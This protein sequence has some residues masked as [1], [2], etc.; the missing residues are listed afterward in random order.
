MY[1][2][3]RANLSKPLKSIHGNEKK[4]TGIMNLIRDR[5]NIVCCIAVFMEFIF[6]EFPNVFLVGPIGL[7]GDSEFV[8]KLINTY[9]K[10]AMI[11]PVDGDTL[12]EI[13]MKRIGNYGAPCAQLARIYAD[14]WSA[15]LAVCI[16]VWTVS[17]INK[18]I[19]KTD[20]LA[21]QFKI[22]MTLIC[23]I[24][25][26]V[27]ILSVIPFICAVKLSILYAGGSVMEIIKYIGVWILPSV[28]MLISLEMLLVLVIKEPFGQVL[29]YMLLVAPSL[30][31]DV[32]H[33]P[34]YK[35]V[36]RFNG[37][38]EVFY[39][40]MRNEIAA[41]RIFVTALT[42]LIFL[43]VYYLLRRK[44][45]NGQIDQSGVL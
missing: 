8:I 33:Y 40:E 14:N 30:P 26:A 27:L 41:N 17:Y 10:I 5:K 38:P 16:P 3:T 32:S 1:K 15:V 35:L 39:F 7:F 43:M 42:A 22:F 6:I 36:V 9:G 28:S 34:F 18:E 21:G 4:D 11:V 20:S 25:T 44:R 2:L 24:M 19:K 45:R 31:P 23:Y 13:F 12:L 37:K 29:S